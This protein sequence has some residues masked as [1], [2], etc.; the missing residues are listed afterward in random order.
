MH[1]YNREAA[2]LTA[3]S[4]LSQHI[5]NQLI[6]CAQNRPGSC[7]GWMKLWSLQNHSLIRLRL[8]EYELK[9]NYYWQIQPRRQNRFFYFLESNLPKLL[10]QAEKK[11][12][13]KFDWLWITV[14]C[15]IYNIRLVKQLLQL[16]SHV[17]L[18]SR[19]Y[20]YVYVA[21]TLCSMMFSAVI[22][23]CG[24]LEKHFVKAVI[25]IKLPLKK[26]QPSECTCLN[27]SH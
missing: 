1:R 6:V 19:Y 20:E 10:F 23:C 12:D 25:S 21:D 26:R 11:V 9:S 22:R 13:F 27:H 18:N 8:T 16:Y 17:F 15:F 3:H 24:F 7:S 4:A 5:R 2:S 14:C